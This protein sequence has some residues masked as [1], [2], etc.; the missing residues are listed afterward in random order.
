M[1]E[2]TSPDFFNILGPS[3]GVVAKVAGV[4]HASSGGANFTYTFGACQE[5]QD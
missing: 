4:A 3:G 2:T 1:F 5:P